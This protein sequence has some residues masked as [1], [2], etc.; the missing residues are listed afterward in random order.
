MH[1][2]KG[3]S[4]ASPTFPLPNYRSFFLTSDSGVVVLFFHPSFVMSNTSI[5]M[6]KIQL[7]KSTRILSL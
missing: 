2:A 7:V 3:I 5:A 4:G 1:S 6:S